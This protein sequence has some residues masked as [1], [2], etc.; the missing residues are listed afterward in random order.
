MQL[1]PFL[2]LILLVITCGVAYMTATFMIEAI[3]VAHAEDQN[4]RRDSM[5]GEQCYVSPIVKRKQNQADQDYKQSPFYIR[6]K[7]EIGI[8]AE[9]VANPYIKVG[10]ITVLSIYMYGAMC[11]K[12]V[13]GAESFVFGVEH[14]FWDKDGKDELEKLMPGNID[15]Y[16]VGLIIFG[17]LSI[18]FSFGNIENSKTLQV[19]TMVLRFVVT[20]LMCLGSIYYMVDDKP[21]PSEVFNWSQQL[22]YLSKV[23]GN[24]TFIFIYHHS[25]SGII[26]PVRP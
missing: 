26:T 2:S 15:P 17:V 7:I 23:F 6:Q 1:G 20:I 16:Y 14:T 21:H 3:S 18:Y 22:K 19:V 12:Y 24:T 8:V 10:I 25:V 9:R 11:L 13:S 4:A 5:F